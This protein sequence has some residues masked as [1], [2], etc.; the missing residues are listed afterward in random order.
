MRALRSSRSRD[1]QPSAPFGPSASMREPPFC[2]AQIDLHINIKAIQ[3]IEKISNLI[4]QIQKR[5]IK[6][7]FRDRD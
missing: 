2:I 4:N 3:T 1:F 6:N 7:V 5:A